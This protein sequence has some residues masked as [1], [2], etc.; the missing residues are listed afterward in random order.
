M[1]CIADSINGVITIE[2]AEC[3]Q[4]VRKGKASRARRR[5]FPVGSRDKD[6]VGD[7]PRRSCSLFVNECLNFD[8]LEG[9][10][11]APWPPKYATTR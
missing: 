8:V 4:N 3:V 7:E 5:T 2:C 11:I 10:G 9:V 1:K 6:P